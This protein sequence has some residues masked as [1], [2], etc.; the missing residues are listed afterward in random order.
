MSREKEREEKMERADKTTLLWALRGKRTRCRHAGN[1][2]CFP[3][4][5]SMSDEAFI[6]PHTLVP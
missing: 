4:M 1:E 3:D 2:K 5:G 6:A